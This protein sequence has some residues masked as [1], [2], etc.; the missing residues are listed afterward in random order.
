MSDPLNV[1]PRAIEFRLAQIKT[2]QF[3]V[4]DGVY[5][6]GKESLIDTQLSF[7]FTPEARTI[8]VNGRFT[9]RQDTAAYLVMENVIWFQ[10]IKEEDWTSLFDETT[11][12]ITLT[13]DLVLVF[14][15]FVIG[16]AR[17]IVHARS[18]GTSFHAV[19]LPPINVV[20]MLESDTVT[21]D[22]E[23]AEPKG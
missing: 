1:V 7:G 14:S 5:T 17:G 16:T 23:P 20:A 18:E 22:T 11:R 19:I 21:I 12:R 6:Q 9:F 8:Q 15:N 13:K 4:I 10:I 2:E 3:A